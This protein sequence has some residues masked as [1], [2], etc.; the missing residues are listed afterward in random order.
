LISARQLKSNLQRGRKQ[1]YFITRGEN[2]IDVMA[3]AGTLALEREVFGVAIA[4]PLHRMEP[5]L[6]RHAELLLAAVRRI[7]RERAK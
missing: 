4:G 1:G 2:V 3:V 5:A 7:T 6:T